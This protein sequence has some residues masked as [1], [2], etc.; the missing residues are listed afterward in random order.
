MR[1]NQRDFFLVFL[2]VALFIV[3]RATFLVATAFLR[4]EAFLAEALADVFLGAGQHRQNEADQ[5]DQRANL[6]DSI[7]R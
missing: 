1:A 6:A 5:R 3:F 2:P 7:I 4:G